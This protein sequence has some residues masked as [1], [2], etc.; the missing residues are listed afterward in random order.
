M[1]QYDHDWWDTGLL[2]GAFLLATAGYLLYLA[3]RCASWPV[4]A[5]RGRK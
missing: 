3:W 4:R 5:W 2:G 1:S